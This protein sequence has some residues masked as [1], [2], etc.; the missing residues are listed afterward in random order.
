MPSA[1][2][3]IRRHSLHCCL[4]LPFTKMSPGHRRR[5]LANLLLSALLACC[6]ACSKPSASPQPASPPPAPPT[7][8]AL[9]TALAG[10][11]E[12]RQL[13]VAGVNA[14]E[15]GAVEEALTRFSEAVALQPRQYEAQ[16]N[17]ANAQL[18]SDQPEAA[19]ASAGE[20]LVLRADSAAAY[21]VAGC[22][23]ARAG[24]PAEAVRALQQSIQLDPAVMSTYF[25]LGHAH[26]ALGQNEAA[27][28]AFRETIRRDPVHRGAFYALSQALSRAGKTEEAKTALQ[29]HRE[30]SGD[31]Q[32]LFTSPAAFEQSVHTQPVLPAIEAEEPAALGVPVTFADATATGGCELPP[33]LV[34]VP[35]IV[36]CPMLA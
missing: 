6:A 3:A 8:P 19:I 7:A 2:P 30:L 24:Q 13:L 18:R 4:N 34:R 36:Y 26:L 16:L 12:L 25:Q 27:A 10:E 22:A 14:Y 9:P 33:V 29:K 28:E 11:S 31:L 35:V 32:A 17:L 20:V 1:S 23:H 21:Y 5:S 15:Q